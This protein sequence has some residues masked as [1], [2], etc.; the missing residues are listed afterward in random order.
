MAKHLLIVSAAIEISAGVGLL[1]LPST[2]VWLLL[3]ST[4]ET[5]ASVA[6]GRVT[7]AALLS[8]GTAC[9]LARQMGK[10]TGGLVVA[11]LLYNSAVGTILAVAG[12]GSDLVSIALWP[13]VV[14]HGAM[15]VWCAICVRGKPADSSRVL[16]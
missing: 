5:P 6:L 11:M 7:G 8:L 16:P 1:V 4:L 3:G 10:A 15:A 12:G 13:V 9:W 2:M 14:V